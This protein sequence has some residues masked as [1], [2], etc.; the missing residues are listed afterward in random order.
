MSG[1]LNDFSKPNKEI[2]IYRQ[3]NIQLTSK[4]Q[5]LMSFKKNSGLLTC[6]NP[7]SPQQ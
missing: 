4:I 7:L 3:Q 5:T 1:M 6:V 2:Y